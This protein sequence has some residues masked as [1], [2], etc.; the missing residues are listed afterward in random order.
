[1]NEGDFEWDNVK[2]AANLAKHG[3][4]FERARGAFSDPCAIDFADDRRYYGEERM[5]LL[6][7]IGNRLLAVVHTIQGDK[8]RIISAREAEPHER[9]KYHEE[10]S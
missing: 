5:I 6:G 3:V 10:S 7:M 4:S 1:M 9:R 8:V 2:A